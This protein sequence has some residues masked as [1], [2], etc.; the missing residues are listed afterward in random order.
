MPVQPHHIS[1]WGRGLTLTLVPH[2][3]ALHSCNCYRHYLLLC[4]L[5]ASNRI[6]C[7]RQNII[8]SPAC[9]NE[10]L[11]VWESLFAPR[12][13]HLYW[14]GDSSSYFPLT[15]SLKGILKSCFRELVASS[16]P[17]FHSYSNDLVR[18]IEKVMKSFGIFILQCLHSQHAGKQPLRV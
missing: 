3:W 5:S 16:L 18:R 8:F 17:M 1:S 14:G 4:I 6:H 15:P 12:R 9:V 2:T 10:R 11:G 13:T 7:V